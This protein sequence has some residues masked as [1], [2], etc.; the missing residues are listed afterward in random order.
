MNPFNPPYLP[1]RSLDND[2]I[3][4]TTLVGQANAILSRYDGMLE[5]II[6]PQVLLSPLMMKEAEWSSRIEGTIAT[7]NEVYANQAGAEFEPEKRADIEEILNY[8]HTMQIADSTIKEGPISLHM[9]RAMHEALMRGVRGQDKNPGRFRT[10]QNWIGPKGC[11]IEEATYVP[12]SPLRLQDHLDQFQRWIQSNDNSIDPIVK[13]ALLHAQFE[14]IHPFD[15][16]NGRIGRLLIPLYLTQ[17][18]S[19]VSPSLYISGYFDQHRDQYTHRLA[20]VSREQDWRGWI[21]FFLEALVHQAR[22][23]LELV[24]RIRGLYESMKVQVSDAT[25]SLQAIRIIDTLF[26]RPIF[27]ASAL[28][29]ELG[30]NRPLAAKYI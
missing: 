22:V 4:L 5:G 2:L 14:M 24:R 10:T 17:V 12:P 23:N 29:E 13:T 25:H 1:P 16:G 21:I 11:R 8:R 6:N 19:L 9:M 28:H 3:G 27:K 30:I 15:D 26:D 20:Q 18:G 7:A